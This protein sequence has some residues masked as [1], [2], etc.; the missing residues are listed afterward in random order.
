MSRHSY[1]R[2]GR[3]ATTDEPMLPHHSGSLSGS[4]RNR[5]R[6]PGVRR[7]GVVSVK[8]DGRRTPAGPGRLARG[9]G[10]RDLRSEPCRETRATQLP[11]GRPLPADHFSDRLAT[12]CPA[13]QNEPHRPA[14]GAGFRLGRCG[15]RPHGR[16]I[17][18]LSRPLKALQGAASAATSSVAAICVSGIATID[19]QSRHVQHVNL[20]IQVPCSNT[21]DA[22]NAW[23]PHSG[24]ALCSFMPTASASQASSI[25]RTHTEL[26]HRRTDPRR[27]VS[28]RCG[29]GIPTSP[30]GPCLAADRDLVDALHRRNEGPPPAPTSAL[31]QAPL[32]SNFHRVRAESTLKRQSVLLRQTAQ[33]DHLQDAR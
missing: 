17:D 20:R 15:L 16:V 28:V 13:V 21:P 10:A 30:P 22:T 25:E 3:R 33:L 11:A 1:S 19:R 4:G 8:P 27:T 26:D 14:L 23:E 12:R 6:P 5:R 2:R 24:Q 7:K 29:E 32:C 18:V 31:L 9:R